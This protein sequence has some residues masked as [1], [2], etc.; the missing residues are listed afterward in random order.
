MVVKLKVHDV[1]LFCDDC[2]HTYRSTSYRRR[3]LFAL[4][5]RNKLCNKPDIENRTLNYDKACLQIWVHRKIN[6]PIP[7]ATRLLGLRVRIPPGAWMSAMNVVCYQSY[8]WQ[9]DH[10]SMGVIPN[11][12]VCV[13]VCICPCL[14]WGVTITLSAYTE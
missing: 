5:I 3:P 10:S 14:W 8:L 7:V 2:P 9:A 1:I 12:C 13:C 6:V 11:V 4:T